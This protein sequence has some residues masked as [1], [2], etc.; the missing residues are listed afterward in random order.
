MLKLSH[1]QAGNL[2]R[3]SFSIRVAASSLHFWPEHVSGVNPS[4]L[5]L[6]IVPKRF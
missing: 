1:F 4:L 3:I 2:L 5:D 6:F